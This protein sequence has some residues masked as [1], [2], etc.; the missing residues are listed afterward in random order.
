MHLYASVHLPIDEIICQY[1][2]NLHYYSP[3]YILI[4]VENR[5]EINNYIQKPMIFH[6]KNI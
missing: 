1:L 2:L 4:Y 6:N 3:I 5:R